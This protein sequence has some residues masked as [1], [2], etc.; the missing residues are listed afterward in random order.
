MQLWIEWFRG[1]VQL[2]KACSRKRTFVWMCL[3]L[4]GFSIRTELLGVSSFVRSCFLQPE[5]YR[6]LLHLFHTRSLNLDKLTKLWSQLA[7]K[8]FSPVTRQGYLLLIADGLKVPKEGKKM[9]VLSTICGRLGR[10]RRLGES[11]CA[12]R[13]RRVFQGGALFP[14]PP[15]FPYRQPT[16]AGFS[17]SKTEA[18]PWG[19]R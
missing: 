4:V 16:L 7:L 6:R 11:A 19:L 2:R 12:L 10:E 15:P 9:R 1:V 3:V 18:L 14:P 17:H 8:L 13:R 5:K